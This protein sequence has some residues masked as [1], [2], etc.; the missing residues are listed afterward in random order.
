[1]NR[2][3]WFRELGLLY[4][5]TSVFGWVL[6]VLTLAFCAHIFVFVD[7]RSHSV[8]DTLYGIFAYVA[9]ALLALYVCAMRTST[10]RAASRVG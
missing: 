3:I 9:P 6:S 7:S 1:M 8:T 5:P 10:P 2:T 4:V